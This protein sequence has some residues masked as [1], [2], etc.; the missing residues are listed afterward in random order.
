MMSESTVMTVLG[1]VSTAEI[2]VTLMH[3]HI[4]N[5]CSCCW[6]GHEPDYSSEIMHRKVD[7]SMQQQLIED[8]F[9]CLDN[10]G[11]DDEALA[12]QELTSV[13]VHGG[14]TLVDPTNRGIGR[15]PEA[16][17]RVA[18]ATGLNIIMGAGYYLHSSHPPELAALSADDIAAEIQTEYENGVAQTGA[19]IGLIGEIGVSTEFTDS[20]KKVL[21]GSAKAAI[22]TGLPLMVHLPGWDRL[23]HE[24]L[25][26]VEACELDPARVI[27]CHM[28]P[29][30]SDQPYQQALAARGAFIEY[31]MVGMDY[32][33]EQGRV[34]CPTDNES[35]IGLANLAEAGHLSHL[36]LSQDVFIKSMLSAHG[37]KG[38]THLFSEFLPRLLGHGFDQNNINQ[39]MVSNPAM[40]LSIQI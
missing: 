18:K 25:D 6:R 19:R 10:C 2:G 20:E 14:Q 5:D 27:L 39:M 12:I 38:Y 22:R 8:P 33:F 21:R 32:I 4:L 26:V 37:G 7:A 30:W 24:V 17:M 40:A 35:A 23:G 34:T 28:N 36:L 31:D 29:S 13:T 15:D 16:L 11:N 1:P 3:E 9:G